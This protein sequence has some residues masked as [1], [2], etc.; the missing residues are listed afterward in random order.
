[1]ST[2]STLH[3]NKTSSTEFL[4]L[5]LL[6]CMIKED[7]PVYGKEIINYIN[8]FN[9]AWSPSH[10]TMYPLLRELL[11]NGYIENAFATDRKKYYNITSEGKNFYKKNSR[12]FKSLL[13]KTARF[14]N[15]IADDIIIF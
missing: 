13:R 3:L 1:M 14:Y 7:K 10:G 5:F 4:K 12:E 8:R 9:C 6:S 2:Y 15:E 11:N